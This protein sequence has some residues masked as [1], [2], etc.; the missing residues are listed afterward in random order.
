MLVALLC[1]H[2]LVSTR[3][4]RQ[5]VFERHK[6]LLSLHLCASILLAEDQINRHEYAFL[7]TRGGL[8]DAAT[9]IPNPDP[10]WIAPAAWQLI[11]KAGQL[12]AFQG[13]QSSIEQNLR[14]AK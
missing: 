1:S 4:A 3:H 2:F 14:Y 7:F 11:C 10:E 12:E 5:G 9:S 13:L 6:P 8:H